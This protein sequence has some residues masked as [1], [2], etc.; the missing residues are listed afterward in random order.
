MNPLLK[1][2]TATVAMTAPQENVEGLPF[3]KDQI[4]KFTSGLIIGALSSNHLTEM[5]HC[6]TDVTYAGGEMFLAIEDFKKKDLPSV[7]DALT[8][9]GNIF[10][11]LPKDLKDCTGAQIKKELVRLE[12]WAAPFKNPKEE[13]PKIWS[14]VLQ[15]YVEMIHDLD[16]MNQQIAKHNDQGA[17]VDAALILRLGLGPIKLADDVDTIPVT[18][19]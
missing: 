8:H 10:L 2:A 9:V 19:W 12:A 6:F 4:I 3:T 13:L 5:Q 16:L 15:N 7:M 1:A 11:R 18:Q 17:G 14:N